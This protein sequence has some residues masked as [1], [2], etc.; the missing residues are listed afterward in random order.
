MVADILTK[1]LPKGRYEMF[2]DMMGL[3]KV[4]SATPDELSGSVEGNN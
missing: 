2:R 1:P 3:E 4:K